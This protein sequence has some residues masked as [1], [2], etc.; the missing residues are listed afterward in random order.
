MNAYSRRRF[1]LTGA[2]VPAWRGVLCGQQD[3]VFTT[4]VKV[5]NVLATVRSAKGEILR[6]LS[7]DDFTI[8]E[9]GR[10]QTIRYFSKQSELPLTLGLLIDT[11][12]S[13]Q[14]VLDAERGASY[15]FLDRVLRETMDKVFLLQFDMRVQVRRGL[16]SSRKELDEALALVDTPSRSDLMKYAGR[17]GTMLFDAVMTGA[18]EFM[19]KVT[20]R[21]ALII[22]SDGVDFGSHFTLAD[23]ID[24][25]QKAETMVYSIL[26][27]DGA[28]APTALHA[29]LGRR[30][31]RGLPTDGKGV[32]RS[33]AEAT[34]GGF[35][36]VTKKLSIEAVFDVIQHELRSQYSFGYVSDQP[37]QVAG[38][39]SIHVAARQQGL[40]V[41]ARQRYWAQP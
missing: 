38:F 16:T 24:A 12:M 19:R 4:D 13:Q 32:L 14:R 30:G 22:L 33:L 5:V 7:Q 29:A 21:K 8:A 15:R 6:D 26:F 37:A 9:D 3:P 39:R 36:E 41:Q 17:G 31:I 28:S 27:A 10:P 40:I 20:G 25:A 18:D 11:S 2:S 23:S 1:L 34:G 35:L